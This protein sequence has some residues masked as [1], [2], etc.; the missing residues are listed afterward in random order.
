MKH[1]LYKKLYEKNLAFL[2]SRSYAKKLLPTIDKALTG[3]FFV[4]YG[5]LCIYAII[6]KTSAV[7]MLPIFFTPMLGLLVVSVLQLM[8]DRPRPYNE[9]GANIT[10]LV[11]KD[12]QGHSFPSRHLACACVIATTCLPYLM[13]LGI[14]LYFLV[15]LLI[16]TRF[17]LG[18]HYPSDLFAGGAIGV[19]CGFAA[20]LL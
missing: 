2:D 9:Q 8:V 6:K 13:P 16:Y 3:A 15:A 17:S 18:L 20:F 10:P 5:A 7:D 11:K 1:N 19:V 12:K 4:A 14:F